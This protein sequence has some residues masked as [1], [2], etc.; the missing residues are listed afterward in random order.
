MDKNETINSKYMWTIFIV[1]I[2]VLIISFVLPDMMVDG[3]KRWETYRGTVKEF[4]VNC[5]TCC[6]PSSYFVIKTSRG[7]ITEHF[8]SCDENL[9][10]LIKIGSFYTIHLEPFAEPNAATTGST[11]WVTIDWIK[12]SSNTIIYGSDWF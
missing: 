4:W 11:W 7:T 12:D 1:V 6:H 8:S 3:E 10:D 9:N 2:F 5:D